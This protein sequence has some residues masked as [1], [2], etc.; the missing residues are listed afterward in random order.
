MICVGCV[1]RAKFVLVTISLLTESGQKVKELSLWAERD[2]KI[3]IPHPQALAERQKSGL[4]QLAPLGLPGIG[5]ETA[6]L[7][8]L[9]VTDSLGMK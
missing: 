8:Y 1:L 6:P 4:S 2:R 9:T 5:V 7:R 3:V